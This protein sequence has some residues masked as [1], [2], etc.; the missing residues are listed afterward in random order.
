MWLS[1]QPLLR[2]HLSHC[3]DSHLLSCDSES[4]KQ[5]TFFSSK[6]Y[7]HRARESSCASKHQFRRRWEGKA[8]AWT[9]LKAYGLLFHS[10]SITV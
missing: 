3:L 1:M 10:V 2:K 8:H 5:L 9:M 6:A 4:K 7:K